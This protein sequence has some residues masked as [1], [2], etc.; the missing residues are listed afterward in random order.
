MAATRRWTCSLRTDAPTADNC[1]A[2]ISRPRRDTAVAW[3]WWGAW[4]GHG[5]GLASIRTA[6]L[7]ERPFAPEGVLEPRGVLRKR[8]YGQGVAIACHSAEGSTFRRPVLIDGPNCRAVRRPVNERSG[9]ATWGGRSRMGFHGRSPLRS[10][11]WRP[12]Q[13]GTVAPS[14]I[15]KFLVLCGSRAGTAGSCRPTRWKELNRSRSA[16]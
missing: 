14:D 16:H 1:V 8:R 10:H 3:A 11:G 5:C 15:E 4:C 6:R 9:P 2:G 7:A 13:L 12:A